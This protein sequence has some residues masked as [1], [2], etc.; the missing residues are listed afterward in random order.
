MVSL[1]TYVIVLICHS[2][3]VHLSGPGG[4]AS[5]SRQLPLADVK[6]EQMSKSYTAV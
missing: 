5:P 1:K 2:L 3:T 4:A 6:Q